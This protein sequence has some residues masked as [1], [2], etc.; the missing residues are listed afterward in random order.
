M[1]TGF[2]ARGEAVQ[3]KLWT[4]RFSLT[5]VNNQTSAGMREKGG[6][7]ERER[8]REREIERERE[9]EM[10][11]GKVKRRCIKRQ[12]MMDEGKL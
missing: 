8:E 5:L 4:L 9:T 3:E 2:A 10:K 6:E 11:K 7:R 1:F 12:G